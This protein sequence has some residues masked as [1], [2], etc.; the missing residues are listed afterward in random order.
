MN[1]NSVHGSYSGN[2]WKS[3]SGSMSGAPVSYQTNSTTITPSGSHSVYPGAGHTFGGGASIHHDLGKGKGVGGS[4]HHHGGNRSYSAH[5]DINENTRISA[6]YE[7]SRHGG[8]SMSVGAQI[9]F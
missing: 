3:M 5:H 2:S 6:N 1:P 9:R 8:K 4:F 7:S